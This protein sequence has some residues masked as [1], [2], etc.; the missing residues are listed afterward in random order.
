MVGA[1]VMLAFGPLL[2]RL[3]DTG[4]VSSGFW[5]LFLAT[6]ILFLIMRWRGQSLSGM[7]PALWGV[8]LLGGLFFAT[9]LAAWHLGILRTKVANAAL[10]GNSTSLLLPLWSMVVL[11]ERPAKVQVA[12]LIM[13]AAGAVL[14]MGNSYELSP[15]YV[16]GDLLCLLAGLLYTGFLISMQH[17]RGVLGSWAALAA[18]TAASALPVLLIALLL[19]EDVIPHDWTPLVILAFS[20]QIAGQGLLIFALPWFSPLV[21]GLTLLS[22]LVIGS[23]IG[24]LVFGETMSLS[25][26]LGALAIAVA[27][28]LVRL[29]E[30]G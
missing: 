15:R 1:N 30:R 21:V 16:E 17:V 11:R 6:P 7:R 18:S 28:A 19:G 12:A 29:P 4:P 10:F 22:Q 26:S 23:L 5:R 9:D 24:W 25:D 2:V 14:L 27:L 20:S 3:A 13:A 8:I